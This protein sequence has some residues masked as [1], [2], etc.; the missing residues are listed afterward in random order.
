MSSTLFVRKK[1]EKFCINLIY[2][3]LEVFRTVFKFYAVNVKNQKIMFIILDPS[4]ITLV[5]ARDI[6]DTY[7]LFIFAT[8]F[9]NLSDIELL[10]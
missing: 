4:L 10:R 7:A 8:S 5:Q 3:F 2:N 9:L 6:V 1:S